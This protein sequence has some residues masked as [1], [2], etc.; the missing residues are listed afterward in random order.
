MKILTPQQLK[1]HL[2][3][4]PVPLPFFS[5]PLSLLPILSCEA[6]ATLWPQEYPQSIDIIISKTQYN[7]YNIV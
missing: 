4:A 7:L 6:D 3:Y 1:Y 2:Y 5:Y